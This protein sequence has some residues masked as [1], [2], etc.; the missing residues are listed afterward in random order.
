M[1][2]RTAKIE[3][4][5]GISRL[6]MC[7]EIFDGSLICRVCG[8]LADALCDYPLGNDRTCDSAL[9]NSDARHIKGDLHY[10]PEHA[11]EYGKILHLQRMEQCGSGI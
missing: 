4:D 8:D 10:C 9:C 2:C 6:W 5:G 1:A 11:T 7:G 3:I